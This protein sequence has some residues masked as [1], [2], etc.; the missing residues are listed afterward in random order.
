MRTKPTQLQLQLA[1]EGA[2]KLARHQGCT[3]EP[4]ITL[5][6]KS[7]MVFDAAIVHD[8]WCP[9][10]TMATAQPDVLRFTVEV[11]TQSEDNMH[12]HWRNRQKRVKQQR[13]ITHRRFNEARARAG[14]VCAPRC[15]PVGW[16]VTLTRVAP[17]AG[18]DSHDNL[19]G[20]MKH[21]VDQ[22]AQELGLPNDRDP[23][24]EWAYAQRKGKP[25]QYAVLVEIQRA[26][27]VQPAVSRSET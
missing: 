15:W 6:E 23:R 22:I 24:I 27:A 8:D 16:L 10:A 1:H 19:R 21:I 26:E 7:R 3:C 5:T 2:L 12:E 9:L 13:W 25:K 18:L 11:R 14:F 20:A 4:D 17:S